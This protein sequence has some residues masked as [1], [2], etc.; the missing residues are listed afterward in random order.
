MTVTMAFGKTGLALELPAG[1]PYQVLEAHSAQ[2][3]ADE[4]AA[5][6][7]ALDRP[8]GCAPLSEL[9]KGKRTA[10][11]SVCDITRPAPNRRVLPPVLDRLAAA[12]IGRENVVILI[13]TGLHRE[14]TE[15]E[16][17]EIVGPEIYETVR[18]ENHRA[19]HLDEHVGLGATAAGTPVY[20]DRRFI[21]A[22]LHITLGFIEPHL[23]LGFS[24]GRKLI[25]P[26]LAAAETIKVIHSPQF[27]RDRRATEGSIA[28]NP[29]HAELLEIARMARHDFL[30]DVA[31]TR[32]RRI[33]RVFAGDPERAHA[34]GA[35]FVGE[36]ML[37][38]LEEPVDVVITS[39]AGYP[40]DL[41]YYQTVKGVTAASHF[42]KTGGRILTLSACTEGVGAPEFA[43]MMERFREP[44]G[45]LDAILDRP[46]ETDQWQLE[47]LALVCAKAE[48]HYYVPGLPE[49]YQAVLWGRSYATWQAAVK[50]VLEGLAPGARVAIV[51][52][53]PYVLARVNR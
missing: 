6:A 40:L 17:R 28:D 29:L 33:S 21:E 37:E 27:M 32:D 18:V 46:V 15:A 19:K 4:A 38:R 9:A 30:V 39:A 45:F 1:L 52:E 13:A 51:P 41:T 8:I 43:G 12:G 48:L 14:A 10:A 24:G 23:M 3:L 25:A 20:I 50:G 35:A 49:R 34:A 5:L 53:G 16:M 26:G 36:T 42:V 31:L 44:R 7:E 47:K 22:D 11:I 2:G